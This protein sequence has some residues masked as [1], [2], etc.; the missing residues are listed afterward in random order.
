[1]PTPVLVLLTVLAVAAQGVGA[2][3]SNDAEVSAFRRRLGIGMLL[4]ITLGAPIVGLIAI[5]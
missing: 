1:M 2:W 5:D 4:G 3:W